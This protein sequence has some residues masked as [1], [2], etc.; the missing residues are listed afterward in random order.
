MT[1]E[2][3]T[4][5]ET[6][7]ACFSLWPLGEEFQ[8]DTASE[9]SQT[10]DPVLVYFSQMG[11][12]PRF[13]PEESR[14]IGWRITRQRQQLCRHLFRS[15]FVQK[16]LLRMAEEIGEHRR[17]LERT[18][19]FSN[20]NKTQKIRLEKMLEQNLPTLRM[21]WNQNAALF[22]PTLF[23]HSS[24]Y[25]IF[26][27]RQ[28]KAMVLIEELR[29]QFQEIRLL[30][31]RLRKI[32]GEMY[33]LRQTLCAGTSEWGFSEQE[34]LFLRRRLFRWMRKTQETPKSLK[35]FMRRGEFLFQQYENTKRQMS[36]GHLRLVVSIAKNYQCPGLSFL[37]LVQEGNTGL[38]RAA[39]KFE[40]SRGFQFSTCATWWIRQAITR[41]I[42]NQS[43]TIRIPPHISNCIKKV[44]N[45]RQVLFQEMLREPTAEE[46]AQKSGLRL[47]EAQTALRMNQTPLSLDQTS[48]SDEEPFYADLLTD[49]REMSPQERHQQKRMR[50]LL[51]EMLCDLSGREREI[52][53]LRYGLVNGH[54]YTLEEIGRFFALTRERVR[55]IENRAIRKLRHPSRSEKL[56]E[57]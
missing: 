35:R 56:A 24:D 17:R 6:W 37:D 32:F 44:Q 11:S 50:K 33:S 12:V 40:A 3:E 39:D 34:R 45:T 16:N 43:R 49:H 28:R 55:Q 47:S 41:A 2:L 25:Q 42:V 8:E 21:L 19:D 13:T 30:Y 23:R 38:I 57:F 7:A 9:T 10:D 1:A 27:R 26:R 20:S 46:I 14:E 53:R 54:F 36:A 29:P 5:R 51:D 52:L 15:G 4:Q 31:E 48:F 18:F 22:S